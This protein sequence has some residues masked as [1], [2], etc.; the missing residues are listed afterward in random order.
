MSAGKGM[1][2]RGF[3]DFLKKA[4][5][6]LL[7]IVKAVGPTILKEILV[8]LAKSK[9]GLDLRVPGGGLKLA[10]ERRR[11]MRKKPKEYYY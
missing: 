1:A 9:M 8:P 4:G 10:G 6:T 2:G 7:P 3:F 11:R 5:K